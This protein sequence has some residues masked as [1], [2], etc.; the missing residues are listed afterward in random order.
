MY[1]TDGLTSSVNNLADNTD[2][3]NVGA[4]AARTFGTW[5]ATFGSSTLQGTRYSLYVTA[6]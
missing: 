5:P 2:P 6:H 1:N 3:A 4:W